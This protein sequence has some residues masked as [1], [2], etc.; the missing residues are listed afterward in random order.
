M[1]VIV[2]LPTAM[3]RIY[4]G[5]GFSRASSAVS[6]WD[7]F[8]P[9]IRAWVHA[10]GLYAGGALFSVKYLSLRRRVGKG[11]TFRWYLGMEAADED[12]E[13]MGCWGGFDCEC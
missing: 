11:L 7:F 5:G 8:P 1:A 12:E 13:L 6:E 2:A 10:F 4:F 9:P 3:P